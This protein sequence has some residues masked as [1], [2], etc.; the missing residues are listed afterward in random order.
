MNQEGSL[1]DI[2]KALVL[3]LNR[4]HERVRSIETSYLPRVDSIQDDLATFTANIQGFDPQKIEFRVQKA[5]GDPSRNTR[6]GLGPTHVLINSLPID[7]AHLRA[8]QR[9][10]WVLMKL[11][12]LR[13]RERVPMNMAKLGKSRSIVFRLNSVEGIIERTNH[14]LRHIST[15]AGP[16]KVDFLMR[17]TEELKETLAGGPGVLNRL[18]SLERKCDAILNVANTADTCSK[19]LVGDL[20][21]FQESFQRVA[22]DAAFAIESTKQL[23]KRADELALQGSL[24][25]ART[26][27]V[28]LARVLQDA[29]FQATQLQNVVVAPGIIENW[30]SPL[31]NQLEKI[32]RLP[33]MY[34]SHLTESE[35][36]QASAL[37]TARFL[38]EKPS[39]LQGT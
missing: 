12:V 1:M 31:C 10:H 33:Q 29:C 5:F 32:T 23:R 8:T 26:V 34:N 15:H 2:L 30:L 37:E 27:A 9:W 22:E 39:A 38:Y 6:R 21:T 7:L 18:L 19:R 20:D 25:R 14:N 28:E 11:R 17:T 3:D 13:I 16:K 24:S 4:L 35:S 36:W